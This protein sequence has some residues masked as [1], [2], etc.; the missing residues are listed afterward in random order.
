VETQR[1]ATTTVLGRA[2]ASRLGQFSWALFDWANQPYFTLIL[3]FIFAPY[4][5]SVVVGDPV[6]GQ[7]LW[8]YTLGIAGVAIALLSPVLGSIADAWGPRK[9]WTLGLQVILIASSAALWLARPGDPAVIAP[10]LVAVTLASVGA[11]F[12]IVFNNTMLPSLV[13]AERLGRLSGYAWGLGYAG[14]LVAL[15][16]LLFAFNLPAEPLFGLDR[17]A[18]EHDRIVGPFTAIWLALF[19]LPMLLFTPD[20]PRSGRPIAVAVREGLHELRRTVGRLP[21]YRNFG[22]YLIA[23]MLYIDGLSAVFAFAGIYANGIFGWTTTQLGILGII[24][25]AFAGLGAV[26]GGQIDD[27]LG[28]KRTVMIGLLGV[29]LGLLGTLSIAVP[30]PGSGQGSIL[31]LFDAVAPRPGDGLF[32]T[33]AE[34]IFLVFA[35]VMG[36]SA[37]PMQAASRTLIARLVPSANVGQFYGMFTLSGK[38]TAFVAP[39]VIAAV[40]AATGSQRWG[41]A[42]ILVFLAVGFVLLRGVREERTE[43]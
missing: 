8:G 33:L 34:R 24:L 20:V 32:S 17:G 16:V 29:A 14:G 35:I 25:T 4:F 13:A 7:A 21:H 9:P 38:A 22:R 39:L 12:S 27:R 19:V 43:R 28:S 2:P 31:F 15:L 11:E 30:V 40:T 36:L 3:T 10:I 18:H 26:V 6:R 42:A 37:G 41:I 1:V 23:Y 5:T